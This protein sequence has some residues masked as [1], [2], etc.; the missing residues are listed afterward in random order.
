MLPR[1]RLRGASTGTDGVPAGAPL[2]DVGVYVGWFGAATGLVHY[3]SA[4]AAPLERLPGVG[5]ALDH[6]AR[7]IER[8]RATPGAGETI[9]S[10]VVAVAADA[11]GRRL[12]TVH[13]TGGDPYSFTASVL[14]W[15]AGR[16]AAQGVR[17]PP[18]RSARRKHRR[19]LGLKEPAPRLDFIVRW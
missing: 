17:G 5:A 12:A 19:A 18:A 9:R 2:T 13:L 15:A 3:A 8:S 11:R 16:A 10:D 14:A 7:R 1:L 4:L 6:R